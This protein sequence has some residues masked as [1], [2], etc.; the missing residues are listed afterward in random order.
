VAA[1]GAVLVSDRD[2]DRV[3]RIDP[4]TGII[5]AFAP[6][7][8]PYGMD[9]APDGTVYVIEGATNRVVHLSASGARIGYVGPAFAI[10]YDLEAAPGGVVYLLQSG[11]TGYIR[12]IAPDGSVTTVSAR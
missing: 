1:D 7:G 9:V 10:P 5:G 6:L 3:R 8:R 4:V 2:N 11:P 12:R